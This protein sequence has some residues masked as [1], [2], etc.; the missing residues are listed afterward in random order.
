MAPKD[1]VESLKKEVSK[2][3][4]TNTSVITIKYFFIKEMANGTHHRVFVL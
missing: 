1:T 3:K 2:L 4:K